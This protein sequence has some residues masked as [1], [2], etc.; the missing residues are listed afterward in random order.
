[1]CYIILPC[2]SPTR[3]S[4]HPFICIESPLKKKTVDPKREE[5]LYQAPN[6]CPPWDRKKESIRKRATACDGRKAGW[7]P[8]QPQQWHAANKQET[9]GDKGKASI[10]RTRP[11]CKNP[12]NCL[13]DGVGWREVQNHVA[14]RNNSIVGE[15]GRRARDKWAAN[16]TS[17]N[18]IHPQP[19]VRQVGDKCKIMRP[20]HPIRTPYW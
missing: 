3:F 18:P 12:L 20:R 9:S 15:S 17:C 2:N 16:A 13:R 11:F 10:P 5:I 1:M 6:C 7:R 14:Q 8:R 4:Y 19:S